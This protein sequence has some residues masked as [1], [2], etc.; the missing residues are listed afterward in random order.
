[1]TKSRHLYQHHAV[2]GGGLG[3]LG[4]G[5]AGTGLGCGDFGD[6]LS[7]ISLHLTSLCATAAF[8]SRRDPLFST[9]REYNQE[10]LSN[11]S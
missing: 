1:M 2:L 8:A 3:G 5:G 6:G 9:P 7:V 4:G 11:L 10:R